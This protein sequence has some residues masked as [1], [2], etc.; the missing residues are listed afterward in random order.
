[1]KL[2]YLITVAT[3]AEE[4]GLSND[5]PE[6]DIA[7]FAAGGENSAGRGKA[8][9]GGSRT[10]AVEGCLAGSCFRVPQPDAPIRVP[11]RNLYETQHQLTKLSQIQTR[12]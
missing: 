1:M 11:A 4:P 3:Q 2:L 5:V 8:D 6:D 10:V 12:E 9:G 7:V